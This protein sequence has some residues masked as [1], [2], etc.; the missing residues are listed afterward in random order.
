M[1]QTGMTRFRSA[2]AEDVRAMLADEL[3]EDIDREDGFWM[4]ASLYAANTGNNAALKTLLD[5]GADPNHCGGPPMQPILHFAAG[6]KEADAETVTL[7]LEAGADPDAP[8][9]SLATTALQEVLSRTD[10]G[11]TSEIALK[12]LEHGASCDRGEGYRHVSPPL[13]LAVRYNRDPAVIRALL[14]RGADPDTVGGRSHAPALHDALRERREDELT[15][16]IVDILLAAGADP[17]SRDKADALLAAG[18]DATITDQAGRTALHYAC[19]SPHR[20]DGMIRLLVKTGLN[21][22]E[23]DGQ[24]MTA[25]E[26]AIEAEWPEST[27]AML[28]RAMGREA[29]AAAGPTM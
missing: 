28:G 10:E 13:G 17:N 9:G 12:L 4:T 11:P 15:A 25:M 21:P 24:G 22:L 8:G 20:G 2:T 5:A 18:A 16:E 7:L 1:D 23:R 27:M 6:S 26:L 14:D 29:D 3:A 19:E